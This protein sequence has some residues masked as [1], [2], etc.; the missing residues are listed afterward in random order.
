MFDVRFIN[1]DK[2]SQELLKEIIQVKSVAWPY[3]Y[4]D[5]CEWINNNLK[6]SDIHVLLFDEDSVLVAYLNL[7]EIPFT[8][9]NEKHLGYGIGNVCSLVKGRGD[10][11]KLMNV[12]NNF[13]IEN[14]RKGILF[15]KN[16]LV[17]FYERHGWKII[18]KDSI[19]ISDSE[20]KP[21]V[22]I[23]NSNVDYSS[24]SYD[25]KSF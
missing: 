3:S 24:F 20:E 21:N 15:C 16:Q 19:S 18:P 1:H 22:M 23:F 13:F 6:S 7:V 12:T 2:L 4:S 8:L 10:G 9:N 5:Q 11:A 25:G 17:N 14:N